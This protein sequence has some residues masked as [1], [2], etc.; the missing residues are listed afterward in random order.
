MNSSMH[1]FAKHLINKNIRE[2]NA[3]IEELNK[4]LPKKKRIKYTNYI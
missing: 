2:L 3:I 4:L 1:D